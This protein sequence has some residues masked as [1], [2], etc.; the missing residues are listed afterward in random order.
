M[1]ESKQKNGNASGAEFRRD[2]KNSQL[3][4]LRAQ[5]Q[6]DQ[7]V[8]FG[9]GMFGL[10]GWS[11]AIPTLIAIALGVWLDSWVES[12]YSWTLMLLFIGIGIGCFNAWFWVSRERREIE[13]EFQRGREEETDKHASD[14]N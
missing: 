6:G 5:R 13:T 1:M 11:V 8:W 10:V 12:R 3:R 7:G 2:V 14:G 4:K 9:L